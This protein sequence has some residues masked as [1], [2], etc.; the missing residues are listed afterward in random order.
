MTK[1]VSVL[2]S[3]GSIGRQT[4][5]VAAKLG[6]HVVGLTAGR[7]RRADG[8]SSAANSARAL[9]SWPRRRPPRRCSDAPGRLRD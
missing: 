1:T 8:G 6:I 2:G 7:Q 5:D 4:L 9:P 3:T